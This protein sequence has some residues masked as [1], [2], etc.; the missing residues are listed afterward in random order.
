[1]HA[2]VFATIFAAAPITIEGNPEIDRKAKPQ[3]Y[4]ISISMWEDIARDSG[5]TERRTLCEP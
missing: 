2:L 4:A 1:M 5:K 3:L